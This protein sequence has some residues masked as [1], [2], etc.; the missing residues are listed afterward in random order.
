MPPPSRPPVPPDH[1]RPLTTPTPFPYVIAGIYEGVNAGMWTVGV[2]RSG[3]EFGMDLEEAAA[4]ERSDPAAYAARLSKAKEAMM[5][6]GAHFV[7]DSVADLPAV[8]DTIGEALA[9]G[10]RP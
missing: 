2:A 6:A 1:S 4:L 10:L 3:N 7:V 5:K 8:L 9:E